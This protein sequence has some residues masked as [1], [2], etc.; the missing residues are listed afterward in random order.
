M[1]NETKH[2]PLPWWSP[3]SHAGEYQEIFGPHGPHHDDRLPIIGKADA[4]FIVRA[5]NC[6]DKLL[7]MCKLNADTFRDTARAMRLLKHDIAAEAMGIAEDATRAV[8]AKAE[9]DNSNTGAAT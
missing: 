9:P 5:C 4:E 1:K 8:I 2:T 3:N 6:H 7:E